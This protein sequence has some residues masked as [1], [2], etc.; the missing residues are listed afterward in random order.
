M[1]K[2]ERKADQA[3]HPAPDDFTAEQLAADPI[4]RFFHYKHLPAKLQ[5]T[6]RGFCAMAL[7]L[8]NYIPRN[9]ERT[10]ALRKLLEAK[11]AAVRATLP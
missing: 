1:D 9:A 10:V 4:L 5:E 11:D 2:D 8:V 6:S 3:I 7:G